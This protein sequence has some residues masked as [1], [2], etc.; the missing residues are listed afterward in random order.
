MQPKLSIEEQTKIELK[1]LLS[2]LKYIYLGD[3]STL[4]MIISAELTKDQEEQLIFVL[5][6]FKKAIGWTIADI[7]GISPYFACIKSF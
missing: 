1:V 5:K 2:H 3:C 7:R 4:P 6:K